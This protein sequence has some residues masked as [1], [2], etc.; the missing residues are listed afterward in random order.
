MTTVLGV[1]A[2]RGGWV[3]VQLRD[4][5]FAAAHCAALI[6]DL[7]PHVPDADVIAVDIPLG[8]THSGE[9]VADRAARAMLGRRGSSVFI[10]P[11][12]PVFDEPDYDAAK[13]RCQSLVGWMPSR[14]AWGLRAKV[15]EANRLYDAGAVLHEVHP[16]L[17]FQR[18]GLRYEDGTKKSWRGQRARLRVLTGAG[19]VLP[20]DLGAA[21]AKVP[22]DDVLDAAAVAWSAERIA[23]GQAICLPDPP[24]RNE[25]GQ[26]MAIWQ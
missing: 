8:L 16:E 13:R 2:W 21:I 19:I 6:S 7:V 9:R 17:S 14:Q 1:D 20:E 22:A 10:T 26:P 18:L 24:Q 23:H 25:R 11:P 5:R 3:G 4:G 12:R 15:L